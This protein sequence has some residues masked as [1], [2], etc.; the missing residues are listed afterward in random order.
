MSKVIWT[1]EA[2]ASLESQ[3]LYLSDI[4]PNLADRAVQKIIAACEN[5]SVFPTRGTPVEGA[6][7]LRKLI[8]SFGKVPFVV[9]YLILDDEVLI[10]KV[11]NGRQQRPT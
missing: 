7:G 10:F 4:N 5:L 8:V 2:S 11:Y 9:H 3:R 6:S 1:P